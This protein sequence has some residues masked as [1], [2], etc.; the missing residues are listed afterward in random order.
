MVPGCWRGKHGARCTYKAFDVM[1]SCSLVPLATANISENYVNIGGSTRCSCAQ[2][3]WCARPG[4]VAWP[5]AHGDWCAPGLNAQPA[6]VPGQWEIQVGGSAVAWLLA[7]A[8]AYSRHGPVQIVSWLLVFGHEWCTAFKHGS[9]FELSSPP[10]YSM[11]HGA[12]HLKLCSFTM[13]ATGTWWSALRVPAW[14]TSSPP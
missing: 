9:K 3:L 4:I 5:Q 8:R 6:G 10:A 13:P 1:Q 2:A 14:Y 7:R 11:R 12:A